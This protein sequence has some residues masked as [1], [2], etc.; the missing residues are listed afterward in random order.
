M[1]GSKRWSAA[2]CVA[3]VLVLAAAL[4]HGEPAKTLRPDELDAPAATSV[5]DARKAEEMA[6]MGTHA[7]HGGTYV[8]ADAGRASAPQP[9][10][11]HE[12]EEAAAVYACPMHPEVTSDK[13]G[14]CPKCG[15]TLERKKP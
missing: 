9:H 1:S 13:P 5:E 6:D 12:Q 8:H 7:G 10:H 4:G 15:M 3:A 11:H 14:T 2:G